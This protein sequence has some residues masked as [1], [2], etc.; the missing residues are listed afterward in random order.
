MNSKKNSTMTIE[1]KKAK[2]AAYAKKYYAQLKAK[3]AEASGKPVVKKAAAKAEAKKAGRPKKQFA[4]KSNE[5]SSKLTMKS[6]YKLFGKTA[7]SVSNLKK[8]SKEIG[9]FYTE[10]LKTSDQKYISRVSKLFSKIGF[11]YSADKSLMEFESN[12]KVKTPKAKK[13]KEPIEIKVS[14]EDASSE[15]TKR[16]YAK[17]DE[18]TDDTA[19]MND[20]EDDGDDGEDIED[21]ADED[22]NCNVSD[23]RDREMDEE[24]LDN[25]HEMEE[26]MH[27]NGEWE[28]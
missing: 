7:K 8:C 22:E 20:D 4:A 13:P 26:A 6:A 15:K 16:K 9:K 21:D 19:G 23:S 10:A 25:M 1:Q 24:A 18:D 28:D 2:R 11:T 27:E 17:R 3:K 5:K 14:I 12:A